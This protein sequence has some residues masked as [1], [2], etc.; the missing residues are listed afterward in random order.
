LDSSG[1]IQI[2]LAAVMILQQPVNMN[3]DHHSPIVSTYKKFFQQ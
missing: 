1:L 2:Y 3:T